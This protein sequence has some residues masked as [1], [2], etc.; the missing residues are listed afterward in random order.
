MRRGPIAEYSTRYF[1]QPVNDL[2]YLRAEN[3]LDVFN[4]IVSVF[5]HIVQ[6]CGADTGR[7]KAHFLACYLCHSD[8]MHDVRLAREPTHALVGLSCEVES[9]GD[10]LLFLAV[11]RGHIGF[12]QVLESLVHHLFFCLFSVFISRNLVGHI[13]ASYENEPICVVRCLQIGWV[14]VAL[15]S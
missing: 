3:V 6:Q 8:G 4:R 15:R 2:G 14:N 9:F 5:Y 11:R 13:A 10:N 7:A 12:E 1:S